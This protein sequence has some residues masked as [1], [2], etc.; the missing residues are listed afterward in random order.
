MMVVDASAV[1]K[2]LLS[3][4]TEHAIREL[5]LADGEAL[6]APHLVDLEVVQTIRRYYLRREISGERALEAL[7]D[8]LDLPLVR[9][10][11]TEFLPRIW[12]LRHNVTA[13]DAAY[14]ALAEELAATLV[15]CDQ[16]LAASSGHTA[17]VELV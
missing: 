7:E 5:L 1:V 10:G 12:E 4:P 17:R 8:L 15:T 11:H 16:A 14:L 9:Y 6:C 3:G 2:M 13:Y